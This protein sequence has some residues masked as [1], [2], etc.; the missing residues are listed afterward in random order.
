MAEKNDNQNRMKKLRAAAEE[1][2]AAGVNNKAQLE[3]AVPALVALQSAER[4]VSARINETRAVIEQLSA[5]CSDY[6]RE[7]LAHVFGVDGVL[8][9]RD[10]VPRRVRVVLREAVRDAAGRARLHLDVPDAGHA[11]GCAADR[12]ARRVVVVDLAPVQR[13]VRDLHVRVVEEQPAPREER[14]RREK[15]RLQFH[16]CSLLSSVRAA[17]SPAPCSV[18][19]GSTVNGRSSPFSTHVA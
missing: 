3:A 5:A 17:R 7:H 11:H 15:Q 4:A 19:V 1:L 8:A 18:S 14:E 2:L 6:A 12:V 9:C 16:V 13:R 10:V